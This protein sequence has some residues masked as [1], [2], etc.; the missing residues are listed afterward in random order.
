MLC[1]WRSGRW[2][3]SEASKSDEKACQQAQICRASK[4]QLSQGSFIGKAT[5]QPGDES[6]IELSLRKPPL[7]GV[8]GMDLRLLCVHYFEH[9]DHLDF[10]FLFRLRQLRNNC[11]NFIE[12]L[13]PAL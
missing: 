8:T 12:Y 9:D 2:W 11:S 10:N 4:R 13:V 3:C 1:I 7:A 5:I 6:A